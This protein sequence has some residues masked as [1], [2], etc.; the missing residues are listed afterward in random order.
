MTGPLDR[1]L[2]SSPASSCDVSRPD[3]V[4]S[5]RAQAGAAAPVR[6]LL[7]PSKAGLLH[8]WAFFGRYWL[9]SSAFS[10][11]KMRV[12]LQST[13]SYRPVGQEP[14][15]VCFFVWSKA[16]FLV[17]A[18][19]RSI[20]VGESVLVATFSTLEASSLSSLLISRVPFRLSPLL[21]F[22]PF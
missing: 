14:L 18:Q 16:T 11:R 5:V 10:S 12:V 3:G 13:N 20:L 9:G 1:K 21:E 2:S 4:S 17:M 8:L 22:G 15:C 6:L 19:V 7:G